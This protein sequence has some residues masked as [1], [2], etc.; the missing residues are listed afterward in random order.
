[1]CTDCLSPS[2]CVQFIQVLIIIP[3]PTSRLE[4]VYLLLSIACLRSLLVSPMQCSNVADITKINENQDMMEGDMLM[5]KSSLEN[6]MQMMVSSPFQIQR[7]VARNVVLKWP[8]GVVPY[9]LSSEIASNTR[10]VSAI[11]SAIQVY[12]DNTC[13]RL[14]PHTTETDYVIFIRG[15]GCFSFIGRV[16][17]SQDLSIGAGCEFRGI[18]LHEVMHALGRV[19]EQSRPDRDNFVIILR[20]NVREDRVNNFVIFSEELVTTQDIPYDYWSVMHYGQFAFSRNRRELRTIET[21]DPAQQE[22]IGQRQ[23]LSSSD[24]MHVNTLYNCQG[25]NSMGEIWSI[26]GQWSQTCTQNCKDYMRMR[27]RMCLGG[28]ACEGRD[29]QVQLCGVPP[30]EVTPTWSE[31]SEWSQCFRYSCGSNEGYRRRNRECTNGNNCLGAMGEFEY[32]LLESCS[33]KTFGEW[34]QWTSCSATCGGGVMKRERSCVGESCTS[35]QTDAIK[36]CG[37]ATCP[38]LPPIAAGLRNLGCFMYMFSDDLRPFFGGSFLAGDTSNSMDRVT[39]LVYCAHQAKSLNKRY[40][41]LVEGNCILDLVCPSEA[42]RLIAER[43]TGCMNGVGSEEN[44]MLMNVYEIQAPEMVPSNVRDPY[45]FGSVVGKEY[46]RELVE[47]PMRTCNLGEF[48]TEGEA[49]QYTC[50]STQSLVGSAATSI[51]ATKFSIA[52]LLG[53]LLCV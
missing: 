28:D 8:E 29:K 5:S 53:L 15:D 2:I 52:I 27:T 35:E 39:I 31:W 4:R 48:V 3:M 30:C 22:L 38:N 20:D 37:M 19:H 9:E 11:N 41:G 46:Y 40:F 13:I 43:A 12:S 45:S 23:G 32:C 16:R 26:W 34:S 49:A 47:G 50:Q 6:Y 17:G 10:A 21:I 18:V 14:V 36:E 25:A 42:D 33:A 24:V 1:M 44:G 7:A 51:K